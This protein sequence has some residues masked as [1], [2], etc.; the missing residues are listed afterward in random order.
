MIEILQALWNGAF[1]SSYA[2]LSATL[3]R[4]TPLILL[5]LAVATAFRAGILNIGAEGQLLTGAAAAT[6]VALG[7]EGLPRPLVIAGMIVAAAL[8]GASWAGIAALLRHRFAVLEVIST[9]MLNFIALHLVGWL[10]RAPLQEPTQIYPQSATIGIVA[11]WPLLI[12]GHRLHLG[13]ALAV[14][15]AA[16]LWFAFARTAAGFRAKA[17]GAA[18]RAAGSAGAVDA[19]RTMAGALIASGAV[20]GIAGAGEVGGV[21][22]ALYEG[23]SPGYGYTA[24]AVA[25]LARLD[26]RWIVASG[27]FFGALDAG[28]AAMQR[29]ANVPSVLV[30]V[31]VAIVILGV[32]AGTSRRRP[33]HERAPATATV[34]VGGSP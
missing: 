25:L 14:L 7:G 11:R 18:A 29:D 2:F 6:M 24:I 26:A 30:Q 28:A 15:A 32:L 10:V 34:A 3:V 20:A 12:P 33:I 19:P 16:I 9:I 21:T 5:G 13:F 8:A 27:I 22:W 23:I 4:A 1:G 17:V 31:I